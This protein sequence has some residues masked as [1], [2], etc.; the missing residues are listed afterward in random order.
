MRHPRRNIEDSDAKGVKNY[1]SLDQ[2]ASEDKNIRQWLRECSCD[3]LTKNLA[4]F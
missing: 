2:G 4:V 1:G 3:I